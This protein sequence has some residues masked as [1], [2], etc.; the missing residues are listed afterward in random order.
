LVF[1]LFGYNQASLSVEKSSVVAPQKKN[2]ASLSVERSSTALNKWNQAWAGLH[3]G[4][5]FAFSFS[6]FGQFCHRSRMQ[7]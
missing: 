7:A 6:F 3:V 5:K 4:P 2:Q 1:F